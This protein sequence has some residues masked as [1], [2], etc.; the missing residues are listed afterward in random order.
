[1]SPATPLSRATPT[2]IP[3]AAG[4]F[5]RT[6]AVA[7]VFTPLIGFLIGI[8]FLWGKGIGDLDV[9]LCLGMYAVTMLGITLGF[10]RLFTHHS[11]T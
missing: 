8:A 4:R 7:T 11:G 10:H 9:G 6:V 2:P 1:M 3:T 5:E